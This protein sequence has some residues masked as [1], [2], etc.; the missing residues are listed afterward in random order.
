MKYGSFS[1]MWGTRRDQNHFFVSS[2]C[3]GEAT[4]LK[5]YIRILVV[6]SS[7]RYMW[8]NIWYTGSGGNETSQV[9]PLLQYFW[10]AIGSMVLVLSHLFLASI[11]HCQSVLSTCCSQRYL[12]RNP[13]KL[14]QIPCFFCNQS[15]PFHRSSQ[16]WAQLIHD[17]LGEAWILALK[18]DVCSTCLKRS[19]NRPFTAK[20]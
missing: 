4:R 19:Q 8:Y 16:P 15:L 3:L 6:S 1:Q 10:V 18:F 14:W 20:W 12:K 11:S 13:L 7:N 5:L 17:P 9:E 2:S